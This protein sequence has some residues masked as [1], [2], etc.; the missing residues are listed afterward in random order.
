MDILKQK[1]IEAIVESSILSFA[2]G[3][4][5][6]YTKEVDNPDGVINRKKNNCF[7]AE[8]GEEFMFY[9]AFVRSFD[10]SFGRI[11]ENIGNNIAKLSYDVRKN[12]KSYFLPQQS[13][14]VD[15]MISGY[16]KHTKPKVT[17]YNSFN[18]MIPHDTRSFEKDHVTDH[19][20]YKEDTKEHFL[21]ELKAG[22]D[23]DNK[24]AKTEKIALLQEYF[25]LKN[26][27]D[28][29]SE[30]TIKIFLATA[31]N[32]FGEGNVWKQDRVK[33][34]FAEDELLIGRDYWNFVCD[35][36]EGFNIVFKQYQKSCEHIKSSLERIKT[37][38]FLKDNKYLIDD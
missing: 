26:S 38:Y 37:L 33:Q 29:N 36:S 30:D 21:I 9:S 16:E 12:V 5:E 24:K 10:S 13:Q 8:L 25:I 23:L 34:F 31:Y 27:L 2:I 7:I 11:L 18:C 14:H 15:Y 19:Y 4:E 22:G 20:F 6:R 3:L 1:S 35:D 32:A 28:Q 17:D